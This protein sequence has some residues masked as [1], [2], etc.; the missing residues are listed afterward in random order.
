MIFSVIVP[1]CNGE[2]FIEE[3]VRSA[4]EQA[5]DFTDLKGVCEV[6]NT[7][8]QDIFE[9][10][11][12]ENG[13]SDRTPVLCDELA[14]RYECVTTIHR[15]RI[16]LFRARQ[17]GIR[18]ANGG[19]I[20]SLDGDDELAPGALRTL[21]DTIE[22]CKKSGTEPDLILYDAAVL[23]QPDKKLRSYSFTPNVV[24]GDGVK[25]PF[26]EQLCMDDSVNAMWIKCVRRSIAAFEDIDLFL[27]YGEDLYQTAKHLD[28]ASGIL[29]LDKVLYYYRKDSASLSSTY[30]E[31]YLEDE[32]NTYKQ[33]DKYS[34]KWFGDRFTET[35]AERK[36]LTCTIAV[37]KLIYSDLTTADKKEKLEKLINDDFYRE[38]SK[39]PLP[40]WAPEEA[41]YV[42]KLQSTD[43]SVN[44]LISN[45]IKHGIKKRIKGWLRN[46]R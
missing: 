29:Y 42:K 14:A 39:H 44:A 17:E 46:G 8:G 3:C 4:A 6:G 40:K 33:L 1:V 27:N 43:N 26:M 36:A 38:Y 45:S 30:N 37:S 41:L 16:G 10:I 23:G 15:G 22:S 19:W 24:H 7:S 13:S 28:E 21:Y 34:Q 20:V 9:V 5:A 25:G 31:S 11:I 12:C 32:K 35:I 2:A 18:V